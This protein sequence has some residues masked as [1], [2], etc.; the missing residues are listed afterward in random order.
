MENQLNEQFMQL[1]Q[2]LRRYYHRQMAKKQGFGLHR[3]Q[4]R[5]LALL[6]MNPEISQKDLTFVLGMRPQSVG[7]LLQKLESKKLITRESSAEDRRVMIIRLTDLGKT[8]IEKMSETPDVNEELFANFSEDEKAE[9]SRLV[10]KLSESLKNQLAKDDFDASYGGG[11]G[12]EG[13]RPPHGHGPHG[14]HGSH[15]GHPHHFNEF[16]SFDW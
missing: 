6:K 8:E 16:S 12:F 4:G 5:V 2:D 15:R 1:Q 3:G 9:W 13:P 10:E 7:E 11:K 14:F